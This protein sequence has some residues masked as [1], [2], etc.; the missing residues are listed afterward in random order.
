MDKVPAAAKKL[1]P[2]AV[3][4]ST[5][6]GTGRVR[7]SKALAAKPKKLKLMSDRYKIPDNEYAQLIALKK[8]LLLLGAGVRKSELLRAGLLLL[9]AMD[10][11][12]L[13]KAVAKVEIIRTDRPPKTAD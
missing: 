8:R 3:E 1:V 13:M 5:T 10:D 9:V 12:R 11:V 7:L 2:S 4:S 6:T